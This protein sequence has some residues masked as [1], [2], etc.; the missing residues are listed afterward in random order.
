[1]GP[2]C[3]SAFPFMGADCDRVVLGVF[4]RL[5]ELISEP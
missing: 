5:R 1:V 4:G 2:S 3:K